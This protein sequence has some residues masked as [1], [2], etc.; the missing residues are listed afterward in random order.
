MLHPAPTAAPPCFLDEQ[1][2]LLDP[3]QPPC[4]TV[5]RGLPVVDKQ[6]LVQALK[7][8]E[9]PLD[10][11]PNT[12]E[13]SQDSQLWNMEMQI[14]RGF[15]HIPLGGRVELT[16]PVEDLQGQGPLEA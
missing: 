14:E 4:P 1:Q 5:A 13:M 7:E 3:P 11:A 10:L 2:F 6:W 9:A 15:L 8:E 12:P 16:L